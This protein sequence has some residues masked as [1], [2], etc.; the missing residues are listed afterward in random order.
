[1]EQAGVSYVTGP[2]FGRPDAAMAKKG[3]LVAAG[4]PKAKAKVERH[5]GSQSKSC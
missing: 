4:D 2:V 3:L 1:M 5:L